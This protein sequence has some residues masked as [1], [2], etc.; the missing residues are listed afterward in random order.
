[1]GGKR[2]LRTKRDEGERIIW[3]S[4]AVS[5][6][7]FYFI[8]FGTMAVIKAFQMAN[9][10]PVPLAHFIFVHFFL[11]RF[12]L[13]VVRMGQLWWHLWAPLM[14]LASISYDSSKAQSQGESPQP[15]DT[16]LC[17]HLSLS[18]PSKSLEVTPYCP[19]KFCAITSVILCLL[20]CCVFPSLRDAKIQVQSD[21]ITLLSPSSHN[22]IS[23]LKHHSMCNPCC[24]CR[25]ASQGVQA[26]KA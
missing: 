23:L 13:L 4:D 12:S 1:M 6:L 18:T 8:V 9:P 20:V 24:P 3:R 5:D 15:P 26:L 14:L 17:S 16:P 21:Q 11:F 10:S 25:Y 22:A 7:Y 2:P 19:P